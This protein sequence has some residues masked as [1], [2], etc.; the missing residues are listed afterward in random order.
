MANALLSSLRQKRPFAQE[1]NLRAVPSTP[2][3][4]DEFHHQL[5]TLPAGQSAATSIANAKALFTKNHREREFRMAFESLLPEQRALVLIAASIHPER[6]HTRFQEF[7]SSERVAICNGLK[8]IA[9][10]H[11]RF[12][13][14][15]GNITKFA[16][17]DLN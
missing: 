7:D 16:P 6:C 12:N 17:R 10:I 13:T 2:R 8:T 5:E 9:T 14:A 15:V 1:S 4:V 3:S 11:R